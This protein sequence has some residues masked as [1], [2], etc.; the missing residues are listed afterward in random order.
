MLDQSDRRNPVYLDNWSKIFMSLNLTLM[1]PLPLHVD[2]L[3]RQTQPL[4]GK[5][6]SYRNSVLWIIN[7]FSLNTGFLDTIADI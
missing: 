3:A 2:G 6:F 1:F 4:L 7:R 5:G